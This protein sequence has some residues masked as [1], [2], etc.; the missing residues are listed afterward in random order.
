M[1]TAAN[2]EKILVSGEPVS[3]KRRRLITRRAMAG[4]LVARKCGHRVED[5]TLSENMNAAI[6]AIN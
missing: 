2:S 6:V 5:E 4:D 1:V 3:E